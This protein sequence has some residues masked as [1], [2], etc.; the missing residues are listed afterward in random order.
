M[1]GTTDADTRHRTGTGTGTEGTT[2]RPPRRRHPRGAGATR[3]LSDAG[4]HR[5]ELL[6]QMLRI[7]RFEEQSVELYSAAKIRG[8]M[9]L[10]IGE[11]AVAVGVLGILGERTPWSPHTASTV[12]HSPEG[13]PWR[14][15]WRRCSAG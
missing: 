2:P 6:R 13:S 4:G 9:H 5:R 7:R 3:G 11:E 14:P 8:F 10:Y 15:S 1:N 12:T